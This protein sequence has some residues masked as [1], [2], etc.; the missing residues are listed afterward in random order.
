[1]KVLA[2]VQARMG[3]SRLPNKVMKQLGG[4]PAIEVLFSRLN[5]S[6]KIDHIILATSDLQRDDI[7]AEHIASIGFD[8]FRGSEKNVLNRFFEASKL[9]DVELIVRITGDCPIIEASMIDEMLNIFKNSSA[10]YISNIDPP[11]FPDGLDVEIFTKSSLELV[12]D[13]ATSE[14]DREHVTPYY[15]SSDIFKRKCYK[16]KTDMSDYR[17]TLDE[18]SDYLFLD[19]VFKHF[20]PDIFFNWQ[21]V[22]SVMKSDSNIIKLNQKIPRNEGSKNG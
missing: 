4:K 3:S 11:T 9:Y 18:E 7:L 1:M 20:S 12:H 13:L 22:V 6:K 10:E 2:I 15:R 19:G 17:F 16:N 14:F 8:V 5:K 21:E